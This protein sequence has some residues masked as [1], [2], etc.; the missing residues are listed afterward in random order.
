M[1]N[2]LQKKVVIPEYIGRLPLLKE[3]A[4]LSL[5]IEMIEVRRAVIN[6]VFPAGTYTHESIVEYIEQLRERY[7]T[8]IVRIIG[9]DAIKPLDR[10]KWNNVVI[11]EKEGLIGMLH[12]CDPTRKDPNFNSGNFYPWSSFPLE[13]KRA[14]CTIEEM[15]DSY[16]QTLRY[17]EIQ[18]LGIVYKAHEEF[19]PF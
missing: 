7:K 10:D 14:N 15:I 4:H 16:R 12:L 19:C 13:T 5:S 17:K 9:W 11:E 18:L 3:D 1:I 8:A 6:W 2:T